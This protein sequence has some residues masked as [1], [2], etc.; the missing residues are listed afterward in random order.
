MP[1]IAVPKLV[2]AA[3]PGGL[4]AFNVVTLEHA[5]AIA[6]AAEAAGQPAILQISENTARY[7]GGVKPLARACLTIAEES[8]AELTVHLDHATEVELIRDAVDAGVMSVMYDGAALDYAENIA[9]TADIARWC[10]ERGVYVEAELGEVGGKGGAHVP[11]VRTDPAE[12]AEFVAATG[13]DAL[14]VA[15]GSTHA[16]HTRDA[17]L[18]DELIARLAAALPV[19][20]VLHGS[21]GVP[22]EGL[23][24]AIRHGM[25]K[26]NFG[27]RLN[28]ALTEAVAG[29]LAQ[30]PGVSDPRLY[31]GPGRA[32]IQRDVEV[33]LRVLAG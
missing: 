1:L 33:A 26:I 9:R 6:A 16:M 5:E 4:G 30:A 20:L 25:V 31:L 21:S 22:D 10:H 13:V 18:D 12:A 27:T 7:H 28:I 32:G 11:G 15:V 14:A 8:S 24:S 23:R 2:A 3:A 19:P 29:V 17:V